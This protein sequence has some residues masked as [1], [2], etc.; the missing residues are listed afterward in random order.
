MQGDPIGGWSGLRNTYNYK[1]LWEFKT[2]SQQVSFTASMTKYLLA[3][4]ATY[5][6][7]A[8]I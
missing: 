8:Q 4:T 6:F 5:L 2:G 3:N 7:V 1:S